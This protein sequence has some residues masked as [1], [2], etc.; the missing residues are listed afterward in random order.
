[1]GLRYCSIGC[2]YDRVWSPTTF[3]Q[4]RDAD[5]RSNLT[6]VLCLPAAPQILREFNTHNDLYVTLLGSIWELGEAVGPLLT[7]PLSEI[8]GRAP[9]YNV[10]NMIFIVFS[11]ACAVS[12]SPGMIIGFRFINGLGDASI[13]LNASIAGDLFKPSERGLPIAI[14]SFPPL[15]GPVLGPI[16]GGYLT[17]NYGWRWAFWFSAITGGVC[18]IAFL[19]IFRETYAPAI[20]RRKSAN[21]RKTTG[22][23]S[24]RS[25]HDF[26][27]GER[28]AIMMRGVTRPVRVFLSSPIVI[29][30]TLSV[31]VAYGYMYIMFTTLTLVFE[32]Q[33]GFSQG[34]AGLSFLGLSIGMVIGVL[35]CALTLDRLLAWQSR[36]MQS[37][38]PE[39]RLWPMAVGVFIFPLGLFVY[40]W[41]AQAKVFPVVPMVGTATIGLGYFITNVPLQ[42]YFVDVFGYISASAIAATIVVR[43]LLATVLPLAGPPLY[44][45]LGLGWGNSLLGF[46]A[47]LLVPIPLI[48]IRIGGR[49]RDRIDLGKLSK[50]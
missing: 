34:L 46:I 8:F 10:T 18:E 37:S 26:V 2:E 39:I 38:A 49:Y 7:A 5:Q 45:R 40:G 16:I 47:L 23:T 36:R 22:N 20:L 9:V 32:Q 6:T 19:A 30:L 12:S 25:E 11:I 41:T 28:W 35:V 27:P 33:Y 3:N 24:M 13:A 42:A 48:I 15:L 43:C 4:Q 44:N 50:N 14:L 21:T 17:Q 1:M 31:S 29:A